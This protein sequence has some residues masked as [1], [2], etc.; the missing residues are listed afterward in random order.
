[1]HQRSHS[2]DYGG[3]WSTLG[4]ALHVGESAFQGAVREAAEECDINTADLT[5]WGQHEFVCGRWTYTTF[6]VEVDDEDWQP[7]GAS[8]ETAAVAWVAIGEVERLDL[9]PAFKE[10]WVE[11]VFMC[12]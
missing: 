4:G 3:T 8:Y 7:K 10:S 6:F 5:V 11:M 1:M 9:H 2:G 12:N